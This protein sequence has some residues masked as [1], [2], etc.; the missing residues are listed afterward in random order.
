MPPSCVARPNQ[1]FNLTDNHMRASEDFKVYARSYSQVPFIIGL[2]LRPVP[3]I[4]KFRAH[5]TIELLFYLWNQPASSLGSFGER[6][7]R[8]ENF[9]CGRRP[10]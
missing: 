1:A 8:C 4:E 7:T 6:S 10:R 2:S 5:R 3:C 9:G